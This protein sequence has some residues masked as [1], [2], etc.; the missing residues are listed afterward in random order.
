[1]SLDQIA[2]QYENPPTNTRIIADQ[3]ADGVQS[4]SKPTHGFVF[5]IV[6][7]HHNLVAFPH[8]ISFLYPATDTYG[9]QHR[10]RQQMMRANHAVIDPIFMQYITTNL[11]SL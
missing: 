2:C 6:L 8:F 7:S 5:N 1:M 9:N 11:L 3:L 4:P 10:Q